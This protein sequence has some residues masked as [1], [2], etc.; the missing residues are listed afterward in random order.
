MMLMET[1]MAETVLRAAVTAVKQ[2]SYELHQALDTLPVPV[3]VTDA[4]GVIT[5]YN[6]ACVAF[7]GR[8]PRVGRDSWCVTWRL[9][10][11]DGQFLP[12]DQCPMAVAIQERRPV[13][14]VEA[15]AERP[16]GT[17]GNFLPYP[18][19]LFDEDGN[20]IGAVNML[21]DVTELRQTE[22]LREQ[23]LRCRRL[24]GAIMDQRTV[25]TLL[26]MAVEYEEKVRRN[27]GAKLH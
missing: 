10:T 2:G 16:D 17:R 27:E 14:G 6:R 9:Y 18:T 11:K 13:R 26:A 1:F 8:T 22:L 7:A 15:I 24:A 5:Y 21:I 20:L 4:E 3:Y 19:P 25:D 23:A 12:H